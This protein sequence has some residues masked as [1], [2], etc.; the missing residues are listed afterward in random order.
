MRD[1]FVSLLHK[2]FII[3]ETSHVPDPR[4]GQT[5]FGVGK[6]DKRRV[7]LLAAKVLK[8]RHRRRA[9]ATQSK[10][11]VVHSRALQSIDLANV[12]VAA[13]A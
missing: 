11:F 13:G 12:V 5:R 3:E 1:F 2:C 9:R 7:P 8:D 10:R 4:A 6:I